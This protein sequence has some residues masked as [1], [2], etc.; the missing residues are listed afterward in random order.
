MSTEDD[1]LKENENKIENE[2]EKSVKNNEG[3]TYSNTEKEFL[4]MSVVFLASTFW[5]FFCLFLWGV[6]T[7]SFIPEKYHGLNDY[8]IHERISGIIASIFVYAVPI[9]WI[10]VPIIIIFYRNRKRSKK[11]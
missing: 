5:M 6:V 7:T 9:I 2:K 10:G 11:S 4:E 1:N 8:I 3:K